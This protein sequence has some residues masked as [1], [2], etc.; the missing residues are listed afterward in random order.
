[1]TDFHRDVLNELASA[2]QYCI[3]QS[4]AGIKRLRDTD[5]ASIPPVESSAVISS[6]LR[7]MAGS[8]R[9]M[10][11]MSAA[12]ASP[13]GLDPYP[14]YTFSLYGNDM[15]VSSFNQ[16]S[17][18]SSD[19]STPSDSLN[20]N[21]GPLP[22]TN[23]SPANNIFS[24]TTPNYLMGNGVGNMPSNGSNNWGA[25]LYP[26]FNN[27]VGTAPVNGVQNGANGGATS[28]GDYDTMLWS[29]APSGFE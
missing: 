10:S 16:T 28:R 29:N 23:L 26:T 3:S 12:D 17:A 24:I 13:P 5:D 6:E 21:F 1:M 22:L 27:N 14:D 20:L 7:N 25:L 9:V 15:G 19:Q 8:R 4:N 11:K 2:G 18:S